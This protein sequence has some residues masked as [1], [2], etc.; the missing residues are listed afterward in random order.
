MGVNVNDNFAPLLPAF[1]QR[2]LNWSAVRDEIQDF[3]LNIRNVSGGQGLIALKDASSGGRGAVDPC[4]FNLRFAV[5]AACT[6]ASREARRQSPPA[7]TR[8]SM[9]SPRTSASASVRRSRPSRR[10]MST[11]RQVARCLPRPIARA[12]TAAPTGPPAARLRAAAGGNGDHRGTVEPI[13]LQSGNLR[14][15]LAERAERWR[16]C[17]TGEHRWRQRH[18]RHQHPVV[19]QRVRERPVPAQRRG[20][21]AG[22]STRHRPAPQPGHG[23]HRHTDQSGRSREGREIPLPRSTRPRSPSRSGR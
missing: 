10:P 23:G 6:D 12:A 4:V 2:A 21:H 7:A 22:R 18:S 9:R 8:T 17:G 3:E 16:R 14:C 11:S 13:L 19:A 20:A 1:H 5:N 15:G